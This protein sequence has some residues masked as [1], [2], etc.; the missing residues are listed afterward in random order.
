MNEAKLLQMNGFQCDTLHQ[1]HCIVDYTINHGIIMTLYN[2][3]SRK[4]NLR[5]AVYRRNMSIRYRAVICMRIDGVS[6]L[7]ENGNTLCMIRFC[8]SVNPLM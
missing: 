1:V 5:Y 2:V 7:M 8:Y 6:Q 3:S 4:N